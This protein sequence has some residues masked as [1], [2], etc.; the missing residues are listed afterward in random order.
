[1]L[2]NHSKSLAGKSLYHNTVPEF[3]VKFVPE[4]KSTTLEFLNCIYP[5]HNT[6]YCVC[7]ILK[8]I[9]HKYNA[10]H[11]QISLYLNLSLYYS[12][13]HLITIQLLIVY[14]LNIFIIWTENVRGYY[15]CKC[16]NKDRGR[17]I[18]SW[19]VVVAHGYIYFYKH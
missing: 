11:L 1:M 16:T 2:L 5:F 19:T 13:A 6:K 7:I 17:Q 3:F 9:L 18:E 8:Y 12:K 10:K 14:P 4:N 15:S